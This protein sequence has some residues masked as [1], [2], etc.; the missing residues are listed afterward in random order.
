VIKNKSIDSA[1]TDFFLGDDFNK[2]ETVQYLWS[3]YG[4]I[5]R[6]SA[7]RDINDVAM[8]TCIAKVVSLQQQSAHPR[9]WN[10][11]ISHQRKLSSYVNEQC[12]YQYFAP[13]TNEACKVPELFAAGENINNIWMLMQ[14]L[15][16]AGFANRSSDANLALVELGVKWLAN[17]HACFMCDAEIDSNPQLWPKENT[18]WHQ[19]KG[20]VWPIGTYWH[21]ATRL[22]EWQAMPDSDLK[23]AANVIDQRLNSARFQT[24]LHGDAKLANFCIHNNNGQI[25]AVDFQ[26][27]GFGV[28]IK[29]LVYFL[30]SCLNEQKLETSAPILLDLYLNSLKNA[31]G[32]VSC[33]GVDNKESLVN[34]YQLEQ[35]YRALYPFAWADFER[36]LVG[37]SPGHIKLNQYS[38]EQTRLV[39]EQMNNC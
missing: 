25:A 30:G 27:V 17:F 38:C 39:Y 12:F 37:W 4:E 34:F 18:H 10:T 7:G 32:Q 21:L 36:F 31:L 24:L 8:Q 15:D 29:D 23:R 1:L 28:G 2:V 33:S 9:G 20:K 35:E 3:G 11:D 26:Y 22:Q 6:Y 5:A 14:D 16:A 13:F 19:Y